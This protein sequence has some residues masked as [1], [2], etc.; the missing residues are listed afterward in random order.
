MPELVKSL[1]GHPLGVENV[2][3]KSDLSERERGST[4]KSE[5]FVESAKNLFL[6]IYKKQQEINGAVGDKNS[7]EEKITA[8]AVAKTFVF[9]TFG[10]RRRPGW[11]K[12]ELT[13]SRLPK[14]W[15]TAICE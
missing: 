2:Y 15:D 11:R 8:A 7:V 5:E 10:T 1:E 13:I 3:Y 12:T 14:S 6:R 9:T 4:A